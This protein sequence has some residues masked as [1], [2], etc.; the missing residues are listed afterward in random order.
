MTNDPSQSLGTAQPSALPCPY[1][2]KGDPTGYEP[3]RV[4]RDADAKPCPYH[5]HHTGEHIC[6]L[7]GDLGLVPV[8]YAPDGGAFIGPCRE[9]H[10]RALSRQSYHRRQQQLERF[11]EL[12]AAKSR[13]L[14]PARDHAWNVDNFGSAAYLGS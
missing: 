1:G 7:C 8:G 13:D 5:S 14:T 10:D 12:A 2:C 6:G 9:C 11:R 3:T 4:G